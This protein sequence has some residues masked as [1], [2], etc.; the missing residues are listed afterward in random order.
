MEAILEVADL[1]KSFGIPGS[2]RKVQAVNGVSFTLGKGETLA[3]VGESGSGK[4]TVGRCVLGLEEPTRGRVRFR[5]E[6]LSRRNNVRRR[7]LRGRI[8]LVFQEPAESLD[9]RMRI[10]DSIE[11]PLKALG[12]P[13]SERAG[14]VEAVMRRVNLRPAVLD[15]YRASLSAGQQQR[16]GIARAIVTGPAVVVLDEP[17]SALD[18]TARA[19][20]IDLLLEIQKATGTSYLLISHDLSAVHYI[21][22]RIAV[23][24][25]GMIVEQGPAAEVFRMPRH[26]YTVGLLSSVLLPD[27]KIRRQTTVSLKGEIP[28]PIDLP[29]ACFLAGR[30]PFA[31]EICRE[32]M[33]PREE[34]APGHL[35][36]CYHHD[37]VAKVDQPSDTFAEFQASAERVLGVDVLETDAGEETPTG[38][39]RWASST[40]RSR[41]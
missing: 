40:A 14:R 18:P 28:S 38:R 6:E 39:R 8:Q 13:A 20:I 17:T 29:K 12:L 30:C 25:L 35:V 16:I 15:Q 26:P 10:A 19:E 9:P 22:H 2:R 24:Y 3:L 21:S 34:I 23:M 36:H 27:P 4:T 32:A 5:G 33:P 7:H 31:T 41:S 37:R 1:Y 11:E